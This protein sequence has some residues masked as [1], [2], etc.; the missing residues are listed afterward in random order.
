MKKVTLFL[1]IFGCFLALNAQHVFDPVAG[2]INVPEGTPPTVNINDSGNAAGVP[3]SSTGTYNSFSV[4][5]D[6]VNTNNAWSNEADLTI[7]T[8][9]G[10]ITIDPPTSGALAG[11]GDTTLTFEGDLAGLYDPQTD[12]LLEL[13]LNQSFGASSADWSNIVVTIFETPTCPEPSGLTISALTSDSVDLDWTAGNVE[14]TWKIDWTGG[15]DFTPGNGEEE[16]STTVNTNPTA[17]LSGLT[18]STQYFLYYQ[19]ECGP[20]DNSLWVGP[21]NFTTLN[22]PPPAPV[23]VTCSTGDSSFIYTAEFDAFE[24]WTGDLTTT[25]QSGFWEIP[26]AS[27]SF[28]TGPDAAFSGANYMNY[29]AS[30]GA[31]NTASAVSPAIDL[32]SA[33]D[34]AELSFYMHAFGEDMGT[35]NVGVGNSATG[36]FTTLFTWVGELQTSNGADWV[37]VGINLDAYLGQTIYVEFSHTGTGDF[38]GDMSIDLMRVETCGTFCIPP[39]S[40]TI[41][42]LTSD[43]VDF[44]WT[45]NSGETSWEYV[46]QPAGTGVPANGTVVGVTNVSETNLTPE[47]D[48][49]IYVRANC[50]TGDSTWAGPINFTTPIQ[51]SFVLDCANGGPVT[52]DYCYENGGAANPVIFEFTSNDGTSL[53]LTFNSGNVENGWDELVVL[54][55]NGT[56]FPGFAPADN[57]YGNAGDI[58]GLTFQ[59]TGDT[60]SFYINSDGS[61]SCGSGST[62][63][64]DGINY[65]VNCATCT[66]AVADFA[67]V[68]DCINGPQFLVEVDLTDL[69]SASSV[70]L[71]D[72]IDPANNQTVNA[73]G[74]YSFGP[75]PNNT[76]VVISVANDDDNNCV[77]S[78]TSLT[79]D[80]CTETFLDCANGGPVTLDYCYDDDGDTN[81]VILTF[82]SLDGTPLN[83]TFNS[84][85]VENGWDELVVLDSNGTPFPGFAPADDNYG[86]GGNIGGLTFQSTGDTISWY[87]NSDGIISCAGGST[88]LADGINYTVACATCINP[89]ATYAVID[90]CANGDQFLIDVNITDLGDATSLTISNNINGDTVDNVTTP[91]IYQVGPFPFLQ[92]VIITV[93]N[94]QDANCVINSQPIQLLACPPENDNPC[95]ATVVGVNADES[96]TVTTPG[97][98]LAATPSGVPGGSC[99]GD[100]D[101]DVWFEFVA[102]G[103]Q[104]IIQIQNIAGGTFNIDHALYEGT[105]DNLTEI[106]CSTDDF[107]LTPALTIGNTYYVRVFSGGSDDETTTF[108]LC[109]STLGE[110]T[111]CLDAL[112]ICADPS[113][114]YPSVVGDQ[115]APPYLDYD[116]LGSQPDPQWNTILFDEAGDYVFS[117]DQTSNTGTLLDID[118]IVWG[119]FVDQQGGCVELLPENIA[120]CSFSATATETITL[121][122]VPANSVYIILITNFSQQPG[123]YTFTQD[124]GPPDGTN[125][126]VVC[127]VTLEIEGAPIEDDVP[128]LGT[129]DE[130]LN[131]CGFDSVTLEATTFYDVDEYIWYQDGFVIPGATG[132][133]HVATE[134]GTYQVQ[135][136]GGICDQSEV[137]FSALAELNFYDDPG[138]V[139]PFT[140]EVCDGPEADG[141]EDFDLDAITA[142]LGLGADFTVSYYTNLSD[143]NQAINP[144]TSPYSTTGETLIVRIEDTEAANDG[145]LGCREISEVELVVLT[146]PAIGVPFNLEECS[147]DGSVEF[148]LTDND[149]AVLGGVNPAEVTLT[150]H[151]TLA[152]AENGTGALTS[153][154]IGTDGEEI[155]VRLENNA[156]G[157]FNITS[158]NLVV[159][160]VVNATVDTDVF[161]FDTENNQFLLCPQAE[162]GVVL[163]LVPDDFTASEVTIE[164]F[165]DSAII[166]GENGLS[167]EVFEEGDYEAVITSNATG[168]STTIPMPTVIEF[169]NCVIP[170]G[171]SPGV[172]IGQNDTFDLRYFDVTELQIFNRNGTLVYS[173]TNYRDEWVGQ[174][175]DGDELPVGTYFY[176][177]VY[178]GGTK[179]RTGWIYINR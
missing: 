89:Q 49:E 66:N 14:T 84:G 118:F 80:I 109:V 130:I 41:A 30:G 143:A 43:S 174:T 157:C 33:T 64:A 12:G 54:D 102:I 117:L 105:C 62:A 111:F 131:Y 38:N 93:S 138:N 159:L 3:A 127:D 6:W 160:D 27:G 86:N 63:L 141:V 158:F 85:F 150:Y 100:T 121:T 42:N 31:T 116:C 94:D 35:L 83:L 18:P 125:C 101:D 96:C 2:P 51:T 120:D 155:F 19:A 91:G 59:S 73:T 113:I 50:T 57:N 98:I 34:G 177:M 171:I 87:V 132:P 128:D 78:S 46:V 147:D 106:Y 15:A 23:G 79:Q 29:E 40:I 8:A 133:T 68:S 135:V 110:P 151:N 129:P 92:D 149:A 17:S 166:P 95:D 69:G 47:T 90:D 124:S 75:Y 162:S 9:A 13:T 58:S 52:Q 164:W 7:T 88:G 1:F 175:N 70:T 4:S 163:T 82:T 24:G 53:N 104:Q 107:S 21:V 67:V 36:P 140:E 154:Y 25:D 168:C 165:I 45:A 32:S 28:D 176:T 48:Y 10:S 55:S 56:P 156:S 145:F 61:V 76:N 112:P 97:T 16:G 22:V 170:Q 146:T 114:S 144:V 20:G 169:E 60:I 44:S 108:D 103:E 5:V 134:S 179:T 77:I 153:P 11:T 126:E 152:G 136:L 178:E 99:T 123:T 72:N 172:S 139:D 137:Y 173:K 26:G 122:N 71:S 81:P 37:P 161:Y 167:V 142:S 148:M 74:V 39:S 119:P 65:T 115:V